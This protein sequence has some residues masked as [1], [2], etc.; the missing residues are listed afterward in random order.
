[1][2]SAILP[3]GLRVLVAVV[4]FGLLTVPRAA[5]GAIVID[6][7]YS[8]TGVIGTDGVTGAPAVTFRGVVD[9][10]MTT[11]TPLSL[12]AFGVTPPGEGTTTYH[13]TPFTIDY[14][15]T[16]VAGSTPSPNEV[17]ELHGLLSGTVSASGQSSLVAAFDHVVIQGGT[18]GAVVPIEFR[19]GDF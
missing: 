2:S 10:T 9:G 13:Q 8:T 5:A 12:G 6:E 16:S 14:H 4:V 18:S 11:G 15:A 19:T 17:G 7:S 3:K 1:M